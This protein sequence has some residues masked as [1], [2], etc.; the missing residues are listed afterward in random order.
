MTVVRWLTVPMVPVLL[1]QS[2]TILLASGRTITEMVAMAA[3]P[4]FDALMF[5]TLKDD[6]GLLVPPRRENALCNIYCTVN[7]SM[8]VH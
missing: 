5:L 2:L 8:D 7:D 3:S 1:P 6:G 4:T